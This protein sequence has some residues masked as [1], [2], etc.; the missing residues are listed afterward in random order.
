MDVLPGGG[1]LA[2]PS[3]RKT[4]P[5]LRSSVT[6][7]ALLLGSLLAVACGGSDSGSVDDG[8][9]TEDE[10]TS[11]QA[12]LLDFDFDAEL[13]TDGFGSQNSLI[14]AQL[15][16]TIGHLNEQ[17]SVGRLDKV[18]LSNV[19]SE[20]LAGGKKK[21]KYHAK[22][23]VAWGTKSNFP[24]TYTFKLPADVSYAGQEAFT[25]KY[26]NSCIDRGAHDV[27]SGSMWYY[28]R[29]GRCTLEAADIFVSTATITRSDENTSGKYPEY[30]KVW[31]DN[32]LHVVSIFGKYEDGKTSNSDA[33][34]SAYNRFLDA[35]KNALRAYNPTVSPANVPA[36][37]GVNS[38]D[39]TYSAELPDGRKV[40]VTAILVD[41][42]T[43]MTADAEARYEALSGNA[44]LIAYNGHAGLGQNVRALAQKGTWKTG[45]Y[46]IVFMNGCDTF[47]YV[48]GSLAKARA[49]INAD[50]P[51]GTKYLDFVTNAMPS[52]FSSMANATTTIVKGLLRY[53]TPMTYEQIF[54]GIDDSQYVL[55]TGEEDNT[56]TPDAAPEPPVTGWAGVNETFSLVSKG[57]RRFETGVLPAGSYEFKI[58]GT[59]DADLYVKAGERVTSS[60]YD[61]RPYRSDSTETCTVNL[62]APANVS[63]MVHGYRAADVTFVG[64]VK[65]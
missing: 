27:D 64:A 8:A 21:I 40:V 13:I 33:G 42:V 58:T 50:D 22:L 29:T 23:P 15:L 2:L 56:F 10:F 24:T 36:S 54:E 25:A 17:N 11:N 30:D 26:K 16:Y 60:T 51:T 49:E 9:K 34:I 59:G 57:E 65:P 32:E 7:S 44:D 31:A 5:M 53:D 19:T 45:Q 6:R 37:P 38:P 62:T 20:S 63:V 35:T 41:S 18:T 3:F 48:D 43:N 14:Q 47:A 12:S 61:C 52:F 39:V 1:T 28:Y 46:V 4:L 55:V